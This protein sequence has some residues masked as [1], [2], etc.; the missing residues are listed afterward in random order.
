M[1]KKHFSAKKAAFHA[2]TSV[3]EKIALI[4]GLSLNANTTIGP[5]L[6]PNIT[7]QLKG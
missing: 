2:V 4:C 7:K 6:Y 5:Q 1:R 3:S